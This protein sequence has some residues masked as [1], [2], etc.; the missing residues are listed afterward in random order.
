[1]TEENRVTD[2][3]ADAVLVWLDVTPGGDLA[4]S[5]AGLIGAAA[6]VGTPVVLVVAEP[7]RHAGPRPIGPWIRSP[8]N[9]WNMELTRGGSRRLWMK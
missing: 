1:M 3:A 9:G 7:D 2:F 8:R 5:A 4:A 6:A